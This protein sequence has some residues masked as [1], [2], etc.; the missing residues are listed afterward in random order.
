MSRQRLRAAL[1]YLLL[2][3]VPEDL[4]AEIRRLLPG[5]AP[6]ADAATGADRPRPRSNLD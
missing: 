6:G 1:P 3:I 5:G 2:P 4:A